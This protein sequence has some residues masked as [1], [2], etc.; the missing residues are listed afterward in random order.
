MTIKVAMTVRVAMM[1]KLRMTELKTIVMPL[2][3]GTQKLKVLGPDF[4][5]DDDEGGGM[6]IKVAMMV[7][8]RMT[9]LKQS[10]CR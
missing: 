9:E 8:L 10:S 3:N 6:T 4:R 5:R 7:K 2:K 1:V